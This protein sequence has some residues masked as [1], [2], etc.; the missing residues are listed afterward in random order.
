[1][2]VLCLS[3]VVL[4]RCVCFVCLCS[5]VC[6]FLSCEYVWSHSVSLPLFCGS[7]LS[8]VVASLPFC[9]DSVWWSSVSL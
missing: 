8:S 3:V 7:F 9:F 6:L 5:H 1:M 2:F 4:N